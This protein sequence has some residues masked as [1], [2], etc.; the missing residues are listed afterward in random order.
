MGGL[1]TFAKET[2]PMSVC[3]EK[4]WESYSYDTDAGPVFVGFYADSN[5]VDPSAFPFCARLQITIKAPNQNGGPTGD[6][7][8]R[9]WDMEDRL[10]AA[11]DAANVSCLML[12]RLTHSG[13]RELVFQVAD[14]APFRPPIGRWM[15]EHSEYET[16][17]SEHDGWSFFHESVWPNETSWLMIMD[18]RVIDNLMREGSDPAKPHSLEFVFYGDAPRL[19]DLYRLLEFR[20]YRLVESAPESRRLTMFIS[21]PLDVSSVCRESIF[22]RDECARLGL[23]YDGWGA[24]VQP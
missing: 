7:V 20:G 12:G 13:T 1:K 21:M 14:Y 22:H 19:E 11:L 4:N 6:E 15:Q 16:D 8:Q 9:L 5:K 3:P 2:A 18:R 23:E 10:V 17:V 24:A